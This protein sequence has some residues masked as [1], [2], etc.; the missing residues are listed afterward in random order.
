VLKVVLWPH[1]QVLKGPSS[2]HWLGTD[3]FGR[4]LLSRLIVGARASA[5]IG[6][7][8]LFI[9]A[10]IGMSMGL[11]AGYFGGWVNIIIIRVVDVLM[12]FP[13]IILALIIATLL[14]GGL[15][16]VMIA[17]GIAIAPGYARLMHGM[18]LSLKH[19]DY[20]LA[21]R[22]VGNY[23]ARLMF[24]HI[25]PN[26]FPP[27][28]VLVTIS[29]GVAILSESGLSYLGVGITPPTPAWGAMVFDGYLYLNTNPILSLV[30]GLSIML[31]VFAF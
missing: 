18:V 17:L 22:A 31:V 25:L 5:M 14:G 29:I 27:L 30:P 13:M 24:L 2:A 10:M 21:G 15:L 8:A 28:I 1:N 19:A 11:L 3:N 6:I 23:N 9:A 16:N 26:C 20:I 7:V 12:S 4:D